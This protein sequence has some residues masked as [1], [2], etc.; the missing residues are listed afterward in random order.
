MN[1]RSWQRPD[2]SRALD[3][4][5]SSTL[6]SHCLPLGTRNPTVHTKSILHCCASRASLYLLPSTS[7]TRSALPEEARSVETDEAHCT[8]VE[9]RP[10][11]SACS[12]GHDSRLPNGSPWQAWL[13]QRQTNSSCNTWP[14]WLVS[15][16]SKQSFKLL[17]VIACNE[18]QQSVA[19]PLA[20]VGS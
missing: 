19:G 1:E 13:T 14:W 15:T 9:P 20:A 2:G 5:P 17:L 12:L 3:R 10:G 6:L 11:N 8:T 7:S 18:A 4:G 16:F